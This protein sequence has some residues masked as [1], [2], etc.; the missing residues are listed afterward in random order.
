MCAAVSFKV[1][2]IVA[3][4]VRNFNMCCVLRHGLLNF[5]ERERNVIEVF[6]CVMKIT[7][8]WRGREMLMCAAVIIMVS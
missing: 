6:S 7:V 4:R 1:C 3:E 8:C 5:A 2:Y